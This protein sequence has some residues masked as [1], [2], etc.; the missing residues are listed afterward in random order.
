MKCLLPVALFCGILPLTLPAQDG[1]APAPATEEAA[2]TATA[3]TPTDP[4]A[5]DDAAADT[6][7]ETAAA[8]SP[9][10]GFDDEGRVQPL[11]LPADLLSTYDPGKPT[12]HLN[13]Q[14]QK[15][16]AELHASAAELVRQQ[17]FTD[18][19]FVLSQALRLA[20]DDPLTLN[21]LGACYVQLRDFPR[22]AAQF[23]KILV[24][25]PKNW[26]A[27]FNL[28]EMKFVTKEFP[29]ALEQFTALSEL[30]TPEDQAA[31]VN[32]VAF[33]RFIC[34]LETD[35]PEAAADLL[36]GY[37]PYTANPTWYMMNA[38]QKFA[39]DDKDA[40]TEWIQS[41]GRVFS[42]PELAIYLDSFI[43]LG[44]VDSLQAN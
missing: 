2:A 21:S 14:W 15:T 31:T 1:A 6:T 36:T 5:V 41:A 32:L 10:A 7:P 20:P 23:Q 39:E 8:A 16:W 25:Q 26:Q 17:R 35:Q 24:H 28:A 44:W 42:Q 38:A 18:A 27:L 22:A 3:T 11:D 30:Q 43:E 40:A 33:K 29:A 13:A 34:L 12:A 37:G 19:S 9:L 4:P